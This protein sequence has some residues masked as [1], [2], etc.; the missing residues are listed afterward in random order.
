MHKSF[1]LKWGENLKK[2]AKAL[3]VLTSFSVLTRFL[4]FFFRIFLSRLVGA[5]GL[6]VYQISF[7]I[8]MVLE[9]FISSGLPLV[10][11]KQTAIF[12]EKDDKKSESGTVSASLILGIVTSIIICSVVLLFNKLFSTLFTDTRCLVILFILLPSLVFSSI[13]SM[14][15][16]NLWGHKKYFFVSLTEFIE[17]VIRTILTVLFLGVLSFSLEKVFLA[18]I[19]YVISCILSSIVVFILF[20]KSGGKFGNPKGFY[21]STIKTSL[22]IT[23]V[24]VVSSLLMPIISIIIPY[25]LVSIGYTNEQALAIFGVALG[26]TFPLLYI[27]S[28]LISSLSMT[29]IPE[30][31]SA[32]YTQNFDE[33]K[34]K[35]NFS[36]K[37]AIFISFIFIPLFFALGSPIGFFFYNNLDSGYYLSYSCFL[38]VPICL[39][40]VTTSCLNALNLETRSFVHYLIGALL[41]IICIAFFTTYLGVL[42]LVWGMALCLG[43]ASILNIFMLCKKLG[44][45]FFNLKYLLCAF[46]A[47]IPS[48]FIAKWTFMLIYAYIPLFFS[49]AIS[50]I[51][52]TIFYLAFCLIFDMYDL[53][54]LKINK[55]QKGKNK[56]LNSK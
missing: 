43:V 40:G 55:K 31:S 41:L 52:G 22:P 51:L 30:L 23:L 47:S 27:P 6:G 50:C 26:M 1:L 8:F 37:F 28:T 17:Q 42:S 12:A 21:K 39:S 18:S 53:S 33:V 7:S 3:M 49:L 45:N 32:V 46:L 2:L 48:M 9:T 14:L 24:R 5:E 35:V 4:G 54:F 19:S 44:S 25:K 29:I 20:R 56:I 10:V 11:S 15:R 36:I 13:Y 38:I 16:G 34:N